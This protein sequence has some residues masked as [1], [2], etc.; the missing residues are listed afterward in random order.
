ML[1]ISTLEQF[2]TD[3]CMFGRINGDRRPITP[4]SPLS[5]LQDVGTC[6]FAVAVARSSS[7]FG[8]DGLKG[9][10]SCHTGMG[11]STGWNLP[12]GALLE[13]GTLTWEGPSVEPIQQAVSRF[14]KESCVPGAKDIPGLSVVTKKKL[15]QLCKGQGENFCIKNTHEPYYGY[16]GAFSCLKDNVGEVA[17]VKHITVKEE[18][19]G[20]SFINFI[21]LFVIM[22][23]HRRHDA[24]TLL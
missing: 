3:F 5:L 16:H 6:Y 11:K 4:S 15:C 23:H 8:F 13:S 1:P 19:T 24:F 2:K 12:I 22:L 9:K 17:F 7:S 14:F 10:R 20:R 21:Q 18:T